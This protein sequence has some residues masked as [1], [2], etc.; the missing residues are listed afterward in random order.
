L[1]EE[2]PQESI[3]DWHRRLGLEDTGH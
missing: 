1:C 3:E 2:Y